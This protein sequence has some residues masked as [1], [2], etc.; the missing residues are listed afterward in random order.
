M[1]ARD[2]DPTGRDQHEPGAKLD[3]GKPR[4]SLVLNGFPNALMAVAEV[5]TYGANKY[6]DNGWLSVPNGKQRYADAGYRHNLLAAT[7]EERDAESGLLHK[8]H[9]AWNALAELELMLREHVAV[10]GVA[11]DGVATNGDGFEFIWK[12][13]G[14]TD[15]AEAY[16]ADSDGWIQWDGG[17]CPVPPETVVQVRF[18]TGSTSR[19]HAAVGWHWQN[20]RPIWN[21]VAY[22]VIND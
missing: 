21:I 19:P 14:L 12:R 2:T 18:E 22:R 1:N 13:P 10:D 9:A 3:A 11:V 4:V 5:G 7:G 15:V 16:I 20:G 17:E 6:T 8:A